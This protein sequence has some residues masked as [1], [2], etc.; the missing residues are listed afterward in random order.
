MLL[1]PHITSERHERN[2]GDVAATSPGTNVT[3]GGAAG[4]KGSSAQLIAATAFD[5]Y[6]LHVFASGYGNNNTN[7]IGCLDILLD[8]EVFIADLLM[9]YCGTFAT[10]GQKCWRFPLH[11]PKGVEIAARAAGQ[12]VSTAFQVAVRLFDHGGQPRGWVGSRCD[13]YGV[14][15]V[16]SGVT[17]TT[18]NGSE[19]GW[20]Q[21]VASTSRLHR[22]IVPSLQ[23]D[24]E[25]SV[26]DRAVQLDVGLGGSGSEV[27][28][29]VPHT[30]LTRAD[31]TMGGP[32]DGHPIYQDIPSGS[33]LAA[34]TSTS[35]TADNHQAALHCLS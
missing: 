1:L 35:G 29:G 9:G 3:T 21:V 25:T 15:S 26:G 11:V 33:R 8:G 34:R 30:W 12:R 32:F 28:I 16:P 27:Q 7:S 17:L 19:G 24:A 20:A 4:T 13:T 2:N 31:E 5:A 14:S 23:V 18:V 22:C 6:E 10:A